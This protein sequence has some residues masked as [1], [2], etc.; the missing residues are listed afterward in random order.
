MDLFHK[1]IELIDKNSANIPEGDYIELCD[2][3]KQ[4]RDKVKPPSFLDQSIPMWM[5]DETNQRSPVYEPTNTQRSQ[6]EEVMYPGL[7]NYLQELDEE[8]TEH[9]EPGAYY[10]P[11]TETT[12]TVEVSLSE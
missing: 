10:P 6:D 7:N 12:S 5:F 1:L 8:W 4:L 11:Q 2:T 3:M 9:V